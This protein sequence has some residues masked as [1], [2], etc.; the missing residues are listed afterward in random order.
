MPDKTKQERRS[1]Y[2]D[3]LRILKIEDANVPLTDQQMAELGRI[4]E[5]EL[6][7]LR[8]PAPE[9]SS[10]RWLQWMLS[11]KSLSVSI[12][13]A[14]SLVFTVLVLKQPKDHLTA[15]GAIRVS[16]FWERD[17]RVSPFN[18]ETE[19]KDGDRVGS[20]VLSASEA[21]AYWAISDSEFN[22]ISD[23]DDIRTSRIN[24]EPGESKNFSSSFTLVAPNQGEHLI[25]I[26]CPKEEHQGGKSSQKLNTVFNQEF[27]SQ[28]ISKG[29]I[30]ASNCM[31]VGYRLRRLAK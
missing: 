12:A 10:F 15:K 5:L 1:L 14:F 19:L 13:V 9:P 24:L 11:P 31:Y 22:V 30:E 16:V 25:V 29:Q 18:S 4:E 3:H 20:S 23:P 6:P 21:V 17:G 28:L 26:V 2:R 27:V 7:P 8:L